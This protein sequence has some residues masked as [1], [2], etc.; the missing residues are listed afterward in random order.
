MGDR[1]VGPVQKI[2]YKN[3][4][5]RSASGLLQIINDILDIS[6]IESGQMEI[7]HKEFCLTSL[8]TDLYDIYSNKIA[9]VNKPDLFINYTNFNYKQTL[10]SDENRLRQVLSNLLDNALKFTEKGQIEFG[11][12][13]IDYSKVVLFVKDTGI[14]I[15]KENKEV[16]FKR[17]QQIDYSLG[18][19]YGGNGLGLSITKHLVELMGGSISLESELHNGSVFKIIL[20]LNTMQV[21]SSKNT[22]QLIDSSKTNILLVEDD[23]TSKLF[24]EEL[25]SDSEYFLHYAETAQIALDILNKTKIDLVLLDIRLPD[26]NGFDLAVRIKQHNPQTYI[27]AQTAYAMEHDKKRAFDSGCNDFISKPINIDILSNK[28]MLVT[29]LKNNSKFKKV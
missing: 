6:R 14:G 18:R 15:S 26:M 13:S 29:N 4:I 16:I 12:E 23:P 19:N 5:K 17:F 10:F 22:T 2:K 7:K 8:L 20:P 21:S 9:E 11:V 1:E 25:M 3:I 24:I 27:I 28:I